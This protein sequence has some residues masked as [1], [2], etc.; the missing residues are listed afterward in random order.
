MLRLGLR[1]LL[2][3][4]FYPPDVSVGSIRWPPMVAALRERGHEVTVLTTSAFGSEPGDGRGVVRTRDLEAP[5]LARRLLRRPVAPTTAGGAAVR[6]AAP[7]P[8]LL[9]DGPVPDAKL[10][11]W[12]PFVVPA[13]RRLVRERRIDVV[14]TNGPPDSTHLAPL[15]LGRGRPGWLVDLEDGWRFEPQRDN[16]PTR[17]QDRLDAALEAR[18]FRSANGICS[19]SQPILDDAAARHRL[20]GFLVP[21]AIPEGETGTVPP[22]PD[23]VNVV[24]TGA[25]SHAQRR[26]PRPI[27]AA[28]ERLPRESP[29]RLVLAGGLTEADRALL[30]T[31]PPDR[32]HHL[33]VLSNPDA[34]ALQQAADVLLLLATGPQRFQTTGK[35]FEYL[36]AGRPI[37]AVTPENEAARIVRETQTGVVVDPDDPTAVARALTSPVPFTPRGLD[38]YRLPAVVDAL[39]AALRSCLP[40]PR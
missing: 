17:L 5:G 24:H 1:I 30:A 31:A 12:L 36:G 7:P 10:L 33:G 15:A 21:I 37:V 38:T 14:I 28:L 11:G 29:V 8:R 26:D 20:P 13:L 39:E 32:V 18:A 34:R 23:G 3:S 9:S 19:L 22:L 2:V 40:F 6:D 4:Y 16:W 35:L 27:L 25:L